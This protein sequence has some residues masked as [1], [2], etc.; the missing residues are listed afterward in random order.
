[1]KNEKV[2]TNDEMFC[3]QTE[4]NLHF[5]YR[6][7]YAQ[8]DIPPS[9]MSKT[10][11]GEIV[12]ALYKIEYF[13]HSNGDKVCGRKNPPN[14]TIQNCAVAIIKKLEA[15]NLSEKLYFQTCLKN[16]HYLYGDKYEVKMYKDIY[17]IL[18]ILYKHSELFEMKNT[19]DAL[20]IDK[21]AS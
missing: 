12:R 18:I 19:G 10:E 17:K 7:L 6:V 20:Y 11:G 5:L 8:G 15:L 13:W 16:N 2:K 21:K 4:F 14:R 9:G 1:M 3:Q